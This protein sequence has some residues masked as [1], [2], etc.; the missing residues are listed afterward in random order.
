[1]IDNIPTKGVLRAVELEC[2]MLQNDLAL[3]RTLP[4]GD[5]RSIL[6]FYN[7]L[8]FAASG[9]CIASGTLPIQHI[10]FYNKIVER[11][12]EAGELPYGAKEQF[13]GTFYSGSLKSFAS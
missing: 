3:K 11:M 13:S 6:A 8:K 1:M 7:F 9:I 10:G 2:Q 5:A 12:I 4:L